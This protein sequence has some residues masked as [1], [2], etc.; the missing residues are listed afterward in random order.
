M[1]SADTLGK[2]TAGLNTILRTAVRGVIFP[3]KL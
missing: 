1:A 3:I 2:N